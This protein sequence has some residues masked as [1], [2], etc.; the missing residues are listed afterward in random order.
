MGMWTDQGGSLAK[1]PQ[2]DQRIVGSVSIAICA[3]DPCET[4]QGLQSRDRPRGRSGATR[5]AAR[6]A[7]EC[8]QS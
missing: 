4:G 2:D 5:V 8:R 6:P 1:S 7:G 3:A